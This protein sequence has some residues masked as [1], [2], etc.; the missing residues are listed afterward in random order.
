MPGKTTY[1][2]EASYARPSVEMVDQGTLDRGNDSKIKVRLGLH[3]P[4]WKIKSA[5][6][7]WD[8]KSSRSAPT[9][10][11]DFL[12]AFEYAGAI[13][14]SKVIDKSSHC[15]KLAE[16]HEYEHEDACVS[17]TK[18]AIRDCQKILE[19]TVQSVLKKTYK[20]DLAKAYEDEK[21]FTRSVATA[22]F[23]AMQDGPFYK[24]AEASAK[25]DTPANYAPIDA[26]CAEYAK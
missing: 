10:L 22:A 7:E 1:T 25:L 16:A 26:A 23:K 13:Q 6:A 9:G 3:T 12:I 17:G 2:I 8:M 14:I 5:T 18:A 11:A 15:Y 24:V 4:T 20:N 19:D 21:G